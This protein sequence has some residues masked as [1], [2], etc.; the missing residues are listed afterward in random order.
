MQQPLHS[1]HVDDQPGIYM[2]YIGRRFAFRLSR[3]KALLYAYEAALR[4][5]N[6]RLIV[7]VGQHERLDA[8]AIMQ[9]WKRLGLLLPSQNNPRHPSV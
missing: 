4:G 7:S 8:F 2:I 1:T 9:G 6:P 3:V 5:D